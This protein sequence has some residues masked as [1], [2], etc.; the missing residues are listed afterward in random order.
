MISIHGVDVFVY[1]APIDTPVM[2]SFGTM[3]DRPAVIVRLR[4]ADG[5]I[6]WGEIWC[7][8]PTCGAEH[9]AKLMETVFAPLLFKTNFNHPEDMFNY[10]TN[11]THILAIQTAEIGPIAQVISGIDIAIWDI[12]ARKNNKPLYEILGGKVDKIPVYASGI[13]PTDATKTINL[14]RE[15]GFNAFKI[16]VGFGHDKDI[17]TINNAYVSMSKTEKLMIDANQAWTLNEAA[18]FLNRI[19]EI[20]LEWIEE[21]IQA[22]RPDSEWQEL[23]NLTT[24]PIAAGENI[25][26]FSN[27]N[28]KIKS[29][30]LGVIQP[31]IC[32]WGGISGNLKIV[33]A[34]LDNDI[35]YCPHFL[36]G[37]IGL[38][39]SAHLL[40]AVGGDGMLEV[41]FNINPLREGMAVPFPTVQDSMLRLNTNPGLGVT[42][43]QIEINN[44]LVYEAKVLK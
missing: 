12:F 38:I 23:R 17:K 16:K 40:A 19:D 18:D 42:P 33:R 7:N 34:I 10:L 43:D 22:D 26:G 13:N 2:T 15:K 37:G 36:G 27:F 9:R 21:P 44:Y 1:R 4:D 24:I 3:Y 20:P 30:T 11:A 29:K 5:Q 8:Y 31:D 6:G 28:D 41:D 25:R 32:K 39:A 14:A 35:R